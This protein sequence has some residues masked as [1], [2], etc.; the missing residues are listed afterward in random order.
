MLIL[1]I[2][3]FAGCGKG[4]SVSCTLKSIEIF[5]NQEFV[6]KNSYLE[7]E[8]YEDGYVL[9][10]KDEKIFKVV[11]NNIIPVSAGESKLVI[12]LDGY[13]E[14][15]CE[16]DVI[17]KKGFVTKWLSADKSLVKINK[18]LDPI[19][20]NALYYNSNS[21]EEPV[22]TY[23]TSLI[24]YNYKT[25]V[26]TAKNIGVTDVHIKFIE[27]EVSF[28][29]EITDVV[30]TEG[31]NVSDITLFKSTMG[32][33]KYSVFPSSANTYRFWTN[34]KILTI[35]NEGNYQTFNV[36]T[37]TIY[38]QF[39]VAFNQLSTIESFKITVVDSVISY[40]ISIMDSEL[41]S[42]SNFM[43]D[44]DYKLVIT[45]DNTVD[46]KLFT[47]SNNIELKS[48]LTYVENI[49]YVVDFNFKTD[50]ENKIDVF[51]TPNN[52]VTLQL[53]RSQ[54]VDVY[55]ENDV[56]LVAVWDA[57]IQDKINGEYKIFIENTSFIADYLEFKLYL[58]KDVYNKEFE[59]YLLRDDDSL[60]LIEKTFRPTTPGRYTLVAKV[61][62][63]E[64]DRVDVV[65]AFE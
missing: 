12:S 56:H 16:V 53:V 49:G 52:D 62:E 48:K 54:I 59:L 40:E 3:C 13:E 4:P 47:I 11:N 28:K 39:Y 34:S 35:D 8:N 6:F 44:R 17:V 57:Y 60:I 27:C 30:Y 10:S 51:Y 25:G 64:I 31:M 32:K 63:E 5:E 23:D 29:V 50:G 22:I 7:I 45:C 14:I 19:A 65:A 20:I 41:Q 37:A 9:S 1:S 26:I 43:F 2:S 58:G 42:V 61:G 18:E 33:I 21:T 24:D 38:Y 36:G 55:S 46:S 15:F